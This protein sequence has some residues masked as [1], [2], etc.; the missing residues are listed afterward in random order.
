[1]SLVPVLQLPPQ[2]PCLLLASKTSTFLRSLTGEKALLLAKLGMIVKFETSR[3][4][5]R[6]RSRGKIQTLRGLV[7]G[8]ILY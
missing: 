2:K 1:M 3:R 5:C 8:V 6:R 7:I 4:P